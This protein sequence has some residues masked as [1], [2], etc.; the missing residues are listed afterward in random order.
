MA[1]LYKQ[2]GS[3]KYWIKIHRPG[4]RNK[5]D[6]IPT[7]TADYDAAKRQLDAMV[8]DLARGLPVNPKLNTIEFWQLCE[9]VIEDYENSGYKS[10]QSA[11]A[12]FNKHIV[13]YFGSMIA[14]YITDVEIQRYRTHR[15]KALAKPATIR[16]ELELV[17][18]AFTLGARAYR[19]PMPYI[20]LPKVQN[21]RQGFFE[22]ADFQKVMA[23][24]DA[25][26]RPFLFFAYVTGWRS[27]EIKDLRRRH[28][29]FPGRCIRLDPG[30]TKNGD[31][32]V[33]PMIMGLE[34]MLKSITA[35]PGFSNDYVFTCQRL[36]NKGE[37]IRGSSRKGK[38]LGDRRPI[39]D[40]QKAFNTACYKAGLPCV[41]EPWSYIE[42]KSGKAF[43]GIRVV[44]CSRIPHDFRRTAVRNLTRM[45]T[46]DKVAMDMCGHRTREVFDRYRIVSQN[47]LDMARDR[48][49][50]AYKTLVAGLPAGI[51][52]GMGSDVTN[53]KLS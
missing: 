39:G 7:G 41:T 52:A 27:G 10:I 33:F 46:P 9:S 30:T 47:D 26:Y 40:F 14:V 45:G 44:S 37:P 21:A 49:D 48:M 13:P 24:I 8:G 15:R 53:A 35:A 16:R 18:R 38:P 42:P 12:R 25:Q 43:T 22:E 20:E 5:P 32:R 34:E 6:R 51:V 4:Q 1:S 29:D 3:E 23:A 31:G 50:A 28:L 11:K 19:I 36:N 17:K 2:K